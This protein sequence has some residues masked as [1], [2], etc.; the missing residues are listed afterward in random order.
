MGRWVADGRWGVGASCEVCFL[1]CGLTP[2]VLLVHV[3]VFFCGSFLRTGLDEQNLEGS[4]YTEG[5]WSI[6][7]GDSRYLSEEEKEAKKSQPNYYNDT[8][9]HIAVKEEH[10]EVA[11]LLIQAGANVNIP[12]SD[13]DTPLVSALDNQLWGVGELLVAKGA[14]VTVSSVFSHSEGFL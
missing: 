13:G 9:L 3:C 7:E 10:E 8:P 6:I 14:A 4:Q 5:E 11:V 12:D 1:V 2:F